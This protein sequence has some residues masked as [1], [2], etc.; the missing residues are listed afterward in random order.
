VTL[1]MQTENPLMQEALSHLRRALVLL[2]ELDLPVSAA[3]L[4]HALVTVQEEW[5]E[6]QLSRAD[7]PP[8]AA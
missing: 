6:K 1:A 3:R 7:T 2:D 4:D 5:I 8:S